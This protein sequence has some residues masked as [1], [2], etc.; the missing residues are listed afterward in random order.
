MKLVFPTAPISFSTEVTYIRNIVTAY[1]EIS[2][3]LVSKLRV[4]ELP[5][6]PLPVLPGQQGV[7]E[8]PRGELEDERGVGDLGGLG[9]GTHEAVRRTCGM[10]F[11]NQ[12]R[13]ES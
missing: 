5:V 6:L 3:A 13:A 12:Y 7:Q 10:W 4:L 9:L 11:Q 1:L 2:N 8:S